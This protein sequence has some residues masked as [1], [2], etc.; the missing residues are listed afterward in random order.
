MFRGPL[1]QSKDN[2]Y[3]I[4]CSIGSQWREWSIGVTWADLVVMKMSLAALFC[5][6]WSLERRYLGQPANNHN[7][8]SINHSFWRERR[9]DSNR[10]PSAYQLRTLPPGQTG[11]HTEYSGAKYFADTQ[12]IRLTHRVFCRSNITTIVSDYNCILELFCPSKGIPVEC[13]YDRVLCPLDEIPTSCIP[14]VYCMPTIL[15]GICFADSKL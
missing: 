3:S 6:F 13:D 12:S 15:H 4:L 7:T 10:Q 5:T 2:L 9:P 14:Q 1:K 11:W 8:V